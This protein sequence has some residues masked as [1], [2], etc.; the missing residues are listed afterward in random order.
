M[1]EQMLEASRLEDGKLAL[2]KERTDISDLTESAIAEMQPLLS[3]HRQVAYE[4]PPGEVISDVDPERFRIVVR[5]LVSNALKYSPSGAA[6]TVRLVPDMTVAR[7]MVTDNGVGISKEDQARLFT[8]F[9][10][11]ENRSTMH[12]SGTGLGL[13]LSREIARMHH[14]DLTVESEVGQGSTFT[15]EI[16]LS[17]TPP[18]SPKSAPGSSRETHS[19]SH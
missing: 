19:T 12:T 14:G 17:N 1:L 10:R 13:W 9:G 16:P 3:D 2:K 5:N 15:L 18:P 6:V 7:L 4:R 8:R 11:I